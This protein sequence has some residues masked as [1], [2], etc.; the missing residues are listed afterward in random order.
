M[1]MW[2]VNYAN[3]LYF[4]LFPEIEYPD[5]WH[6]TFLSR[7][8]SSTIQWPS[9]NLMVRFWQEPQG[10]L[11]LFPAVEFDSFD[12]NIRCCERENMFQANS[13]V[14]AER[15]FSF[16]VLLHIYVDT[17]RICIIVYV[18]R[19]A[20]F[21]PWPNWIRFRDLTSIFCCLHYRLPNCWITTHV[22]CLWRGI[23]VANEMWVS[24]ITRRRAW[25]RDKD[26]GSLF[27]RRMLSSPVS[28]RSSQSLLFLLDLHQ[29]Q[30]LPQSKRLHLIS[31]A[32][33]LAS[34][35]SSIYFLLV[36]MEIW[37][38]ENADA[39]TPLSLSQCPIDVFQKQR[40]VTYN[41][42]TADNSLHS[43]GCITALPLPTF[44]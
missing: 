36:F 12:D 41:H 6:Q 25:I 22:S 26:A 39:F 11:N 13:S 27:W 35:Q 23:S 32:K 28:I 37:T 7:S 18:Q 3:K 1:C 44:S 21:W 14:A 10:F 42:L 30:K 4:D 40:S 17:Q 33:V 38:G 20:A 43:E 31:S 15:N 29:K 9:S 34:Q 8:S 2:M 16:H 5:R 24:P 19:N